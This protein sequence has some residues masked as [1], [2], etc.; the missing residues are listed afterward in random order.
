MRV[1]TSDAGR[2]QFSMENA[3]SVSTRRAKPRARLD[4]LADRIDAGPVAL[5]ARQMPLGGPPAVAVHD[6]RDMGWQ[7]LEADLPGERLVGMARRDPRQQLL[8]RH[9]RAPRFCGVASNQS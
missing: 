5:H 8:K 7:A 4:G 2:F 3:Y 6:D 1:L 9:V